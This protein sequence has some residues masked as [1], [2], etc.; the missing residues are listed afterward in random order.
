MQ[1]NSHLSRFP[2]YSAKYRYVI[3]DTEPRSLLIGWG[4]AVILWRPPTFVRFRRENR[5]FS[6]FL[7]CD[8]KESE[9]KM[10]FHF[11]RYFVK[12]V[13]CFPTPRFKDIKHTI[14]YINTVWYKHSFQILNFNKIDPFNYIQRCFTLPMNSVFYKN[15]KNVRHSFFDQTHVAVLPI[16]YIKT[17]IS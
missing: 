17:I 8:K 6:H 4:V 13:E 10:T 3:H 1:G 12:L 11:I 5:Q 16:L 7:T 15:E 2:V 14:R 9:K